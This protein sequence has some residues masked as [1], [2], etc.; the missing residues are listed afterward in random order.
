MRFE[1]QE[2][3]AVRVEQGGEALGEGKV[4]ETDGVGMVFEGVD[5]G[6]ELG[7]FVDARAGVGRLAVDGGGF[8]VAHLAVVREKRWREGVVNAKDASHLGS[9]EKGPCIQE[10]PDLLFVR[11]LE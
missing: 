8:S 7:V 9:S 2:E 6:G 1:P 5:R 4:L 3:T 11:M 10:S